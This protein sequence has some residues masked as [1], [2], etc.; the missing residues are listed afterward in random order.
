MFG[1]SLGLGFKLPT[2]T[3][4]PW[5]YMHWSNLPLVV[6]AQSIA[7]ALPPCL[8]PPRDPHQGLSLQHSPCGNMAR[9]LHVAH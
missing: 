7:A 2:M 3:P 1:T 9:S 5:P 6:Q 8:L 4:K